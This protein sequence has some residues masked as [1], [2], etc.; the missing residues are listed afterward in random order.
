MADAFEARLLETMVQAWRIAR[1]I[2]TVDGSGAEDFRQYLLQVGESDDP[3]FELAGNLVNFLA[4]I[5]HSVIDRSFDRH[6]V[7]VAIEMAGRYPEYADLPDELPQDLIFTDPYAK[8]AETLYRK[9]ATGFIIYSRWK[10]GIDDGFDNPDYPREQYLHSWPSS[11]DRAD[12]ET[13][14]NYLPT[15]PDR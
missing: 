6:A 12:R 2:S 15:N 4:T 13:V 3:T 5:A 7:E 9:T 10:N 1:T 11:T 8:G 14:V